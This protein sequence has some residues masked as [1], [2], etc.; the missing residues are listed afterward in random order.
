MPSPE[1]LTDGSI[2]KNEPRM[3]V[4]RTSAAITRHHHGV[5][6][7]APAR[8]RA[9]VAA[10]DVAT[11]AL[12]GA[13]GAAAPAVPFPTM[14]KGAKP[15]EAI[16]GTGIAPPGA[17][18]AGLS[19]REYAD[20]VLK[21]IDW[22]KRDIMLNVP[23]T[24]DRLVLGG[25]RRSMA[26]TFDRADVS[27]AF[28]DY[29]TDWNFRVSVPKG[30][31]VLRLV[32]AGIAAHGG[33]HRVFLFGQSQGAFIIGEAMSDPKLSAMVERAAIWGHPWISRHHYPPGVDQRVWEFSN[34]DDPITLPL[35]G[36]ARELIEM[37]G[38][39]HDKGVGAV[40]PGAV[41]KVLANAAV[42]GWAAMWIARSKFI[43]E[44]V[45]NDPHGYDHAYGTGMRFLLEAMHT[46][47]AISTDEAARR[48]SAVKQ[49]AAAPLDGWRMF[50]D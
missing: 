22:S 42:A 41:F 33:Q 30:L 13:P 1:R 31:E 34:A 12:G 19:A 36:S 25:M 38:T 39:M 28:M 43:P 35:R 11:L 14:P 15:G 46:L 16:P 24:G 29:D 10:H 18:P 6:V 2:G 23:G 26:L 50:R 37:L 32:L 8:A 40:L 5:S 3:K 17:L 20:H 21:Q 49:A 27:F 7:P 9:G 48:A 44:S 45:M 47:P 4:F